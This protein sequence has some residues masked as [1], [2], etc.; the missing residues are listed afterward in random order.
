[1]NNSF[2]TEALLKKLK[3]HP[4]ILNS[5]MPMGYVP[6][7]PVLCIL[8][9]NLCMKVPF[10]KYKITGE[11]D[12]T[13]VYPTRYLATVTIPEEQIV[14]FED[15]ALQEAFAKVT[16]SDPVGTFRHEAI[17]HLDKTAYHHLRSALFEE[18]D[19]IVNSLTLGQPYSSK[20]EINFKHLFN[21][22]LEP[23]LRPFYKAI[24]SSFA[25]KYITE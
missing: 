12:K 7:L 2:S 9:G 10:L 25:N 11:V 16:F 14:A 22:L 15:L 20:D 23:S 13:F 21:T 8:N 24:D 3:T 6:G 18:Y 4:F 19:K 17:K 5:S 1:M